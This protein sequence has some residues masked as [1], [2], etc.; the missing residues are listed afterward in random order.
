MTDSDRL[1]TG[2]SLT[3]HREGKKAHLVSFVLAYTWERASRAFEKEMQNGIVQAEGGKCLLNGLYLS[4]C[5]LGFGVL[6][7]V[8]TPRKDHQQQKSVM[9][10]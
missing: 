5:P 10:S 7:S 2:F 8:N 9:E 3:P 6:W 4:V 1:E